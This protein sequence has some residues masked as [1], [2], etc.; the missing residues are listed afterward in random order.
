MNYWVTYMILIVLDSFLMLEVFA[1][2]HEQLQLTPLSPFMYVL[3]NLDN[4]D[5]FYF[6]LLFFFFSKP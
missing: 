6:Y 4:A 2:F 1:V 5:F 3:C